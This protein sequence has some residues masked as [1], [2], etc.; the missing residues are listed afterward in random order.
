MLKSMRHGGR[1]NWP[2]IRVLILRRSFPELRRTLITRAKDQYA[3]AVNE[4]R[5]KWRR[6]MEAVREELRRLGVL[7]PADEEDRNRKRRKK[8]AVA[9]R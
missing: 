7:P 4:G 5:V 3:D 2:G 1:E 9:S 8:R 6:E